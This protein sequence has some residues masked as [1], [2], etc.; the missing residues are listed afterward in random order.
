MAVHQK[1]NSM[2][3]KS[4]RCSVV[5]C[6]KFAIRPLATTCKPHFYERRED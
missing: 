2:S 6:N 4:V 1:G 5:G 3:G